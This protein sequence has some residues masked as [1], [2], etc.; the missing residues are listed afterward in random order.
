MMELVDMLDLGSSAARRGGSE[1]KKYASKAELKGFRKGKTPIG[2]V[3]KMY[4][5]SVLAQVINDKLQKS[6]TDYIESEKLELL[7]QP[8][9]SEDQDGD[10]DFNPNDLQDYT[11]KYDIGLSPEFELQGLTDKD[12]YDIHDVQL[13]DEVVDEE[14]GFVTKKFG[15]QED[16]DGAVE[17]RDII[18]V[19]AEELE[20]GKPKK[21]GWATEFTVMVDTLADNYKET[22]LKL[23]KGDT[24]TFDPYTLEDGKERDYVHKYI[25]NVKTEEGE[26]E[27]IIGNEFTGTIAGIK[28]KHYD[29]QATQLMYREIMDKLIADTTVDLPADFLKRW[30]TETNEEASAEDIEKDFDG[31]LKNLKWTLIKGKLSSMF[32]VKV[33]G[34][35]V[36][37]AMEQKVR[38]YF[39]Q[40]G[41]DD[42]YMGQ[43]MQNMM[44]NREEVNKTYEE[45]QAE[46]I[47]SKIGETVKQKKKA[48]SLDAF[49][50]MVKELNAKQGAA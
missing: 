47:F 25:L 16:M 23:S 12:S 29:N 7:G 34:E 19:H 37:A 27:P 13:T 20:G 41:M 4:G 43:I 40:Y 15:V 31:F 8:L 46:K 22:I 18:T 3:K 9:P 26:E 36:Y 45:L 42:S 39:G 49:N 14:I 1:L 33:E 44:Q 30:V 6:L 38:G 50:D 17:V 35:E 11:F 32:E 24:F 2:V 28:Q 48:I 5:Q 21:D 10:I